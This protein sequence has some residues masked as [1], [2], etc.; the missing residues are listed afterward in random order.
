MGHTMY[1]F[2]GIWI[3]VSDFVTGFLSI[4]CVGLGA[5]WYLDMLGVELVGF[6]FIFQYWQ[7]LFCTLSSTSQK[8]GIYPSV[9]AI[10]N[11][12]TRNE[13]SNKRRYI[14]QYKTRNTEIQLSINHQLLPFIQ[15]SSH[16]RQI[17]NHLITMSNKQQLLRVGWQTEVRGRF[18]LR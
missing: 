10:I 18:S 17:R 11:K 9:F 7:I 8:V 15:Q 4:C 5:G 12:Y 14:H 3:F 2:S 1:G 13:M 6:M 16:P